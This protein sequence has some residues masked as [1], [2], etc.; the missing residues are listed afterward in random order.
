M[1]SIPTAG[2]EEAGATSVSVT[3]GTTITTPSIASIP[4]PVSDASRVPFPSDSQD[5]W[6]N[7][8]ESNLAKWKHENAMQ[9][10]KAERVRSEW[11]AKRSTI[12]PTHIIGASAG[13]KEPK[14]GEH[15]AK[16]QRSATGEL[17]IGWEEV[18]DA[19]SSALVSA[20]TTPVSFYLDFIP[21]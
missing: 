20:N 13:L 1:S 17:G 2:S 7:E 15:L 12:G 14:L 16:I 18:S 21:L 9:R 3:P 10:E 11:E 6:K 19:D 8:Q 4:Q 5:E